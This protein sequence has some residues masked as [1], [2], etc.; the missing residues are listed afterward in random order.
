[1]D[2]WTDNPTRKALRLAGLALFFCLLASYPLQRRVQFDAINTKLVYLADWRGFQEVAR[3]SSRSD[4]A[5]LADL[6]AAGVSAVAV[7]PTS[8]DQLAADGAL[9]YLPAPSPGHTRMRI[10]YPDRFSIASACAGLFRETAVSGDIVDVPVAGELFR[11]TPLFFD[12]GLMEKARAQGLEIVYRIPNAIWGGPR[13]IRHFTQTLS[14]GSLI[15][16]DQDSVLG[17]PSSIPLAAEAFEARQLRIGDV[18]FSGQDGIDEMLASRPLKDVFIHSIPPKELAKLPYARLFP[19]WL[20]AAEERNIRWFYLHPPDAMNVSREGMALYDASLDYVRELVRRLEEAGYVKGQPVEARPFLEDATSGPPGRLSKLVAA[21]GAFCL[22]WAMMVL[23]ELMP[24]GLLALGLLPVAAALLLF[25]KAAA[26]AAAVAAPTLGAMLFERRTRE[27]PGILRIAGELLLLFGLS[28]LGGTLVYELL[29]D[30]AF[31]LHRAAFSGVKLV[32]LGPVALACLD[33]IR[34]ARMPVLS[35]RVRALDLALLTAV[36]LAGAVYVMR[37]GN[38][39]PIKA[40]D[41][42]QGLRDRLEATLP[43]RPRTKEFLVGYP[44]LILLAML[45][46]GRG[47]A[48]GPNWRLRLLLLAA[49][50]VAPVSISNAFCHLHTPYALNVTR[51]AMGLAAGLLGLL[52]LGPLRRAIRVA[53]NG[54][55]ASVSGYF[56]YGNAGDEWILRRQLSALGEAVGDRLQLLAFTRQPG[57]WLEGTD[58]VHAGGRWS[59]TQVMAGMLLSPVHV[60]SGGGLFQ[61][62]SGRLTPLYY[63]AFPA[64]NRLL[65][66]HYLAF[67]GQSYGSLRWAAVRRA[68]AWYASRADLVM[69]RDA[70]S[71]AALRQWG[72]E[73]GISPGSWQRLSTGTDLIFWERLPEPAAAIRRL[74]LGVNLRPSGRISPADVRALV[75]GCRRLASARGMELRF[76]AMHPSEDLPFLEGLATPAEIVE[77]T[78]ENSVEVFSGLAALVAMRYHAMLLAAGTRTPL[79]AV[80]Y[81]SKTDNFLD[82]TGHPHRLAPDEEG[83]SEPAATADAVH[84]SLASLL[85]EPGP[86]TE[87]LAVWAEEQLQAGAVA[88][89]Q[90]VHSVRSALTD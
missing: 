44:A 34:R 16:C 75:E 8:T 55:Y 49:G 17:W 51:G 89:A 83:R 57:P 71:A 77:V 79:L 30:P 88:R 41:A 26:L 46:T 10:V 69:P 28:L 11:S 12:Y 38:F 72:E 45:G 13:I 87:R 7:R 43:A 19:R 35:A 29:C 4:E 68:V 60:S 21:L 53:G 36:A 22:T 47:R 84:D 85:A 50:T 78:P 61:D 67:V 5:V 39:S 25:P 14:T 3:A 58:G 23:F 74:Q 76:L 6:A 54:P 48:T 64:I 32:Y 80:S 70:A 27:D 40:T 31:L 24:G 2:T 1:M 65:G 15:L 86:A 66:T 82:D 33:L 73:A 81:D 20:R 62:A 42:E 9:E 56:G 52:A 37:S 90:F 59:L 18:E 63:L